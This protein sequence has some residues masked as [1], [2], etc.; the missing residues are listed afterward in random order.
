MHAPTDGAAQRQEAQRAPIWHA[1][2]QQ[3]G[4]EEEFVNSLSSL[5]KRILDGAIT[6]TEAEAQTRQEHE[7]TALETSESTA[8]EVGGQAG[9]SQMRTRILT[10]AQACVEAL[11]RKEGAQGRLPQAA[12]A[13]T[14]TAPKRQRK[15]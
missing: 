7:E 9:L 5:G 4:W 3:P 2:Q 1:G 11:K 6:L 12:S 14:T 8:R 13:S 15:A 10:E